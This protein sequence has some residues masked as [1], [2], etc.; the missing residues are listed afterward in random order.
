MKEYAVIGYF[1]Q[2][3]SSD[4]FELKKELYQLG[5]SDY[6]L[7]NPDAH[8]TLCSFENLNNE[9]LEKVKTILEEYSGCKLKFAGI[10]SFTKSNILFMSI[11]KTPA[12]FALNQALFK[13]TNAKQDSLYS[14]LHWY[15]HVTIANRIEEQFF[16]SAFQLCRQKANFCEAT[17]DCIRVVA[18]ELDSSGHI[19]SKTVVYSKKYNKK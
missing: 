13:A 14:P 11:V 9:V 6:F 12:L 16:L 18:F 10:G 7:S 15:P 19:L 4:F 5:L 1:D 8:L 17:L 2:Q 3:T